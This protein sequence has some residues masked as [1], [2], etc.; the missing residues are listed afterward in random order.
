MWNDWEAAISNPG[1][2]HASIASGNPGVRPKVAAEDDEDATTLAGPEWYPTMDV[3]WAGG[4]VLDGDLLY[5]EKDPNLEYRAAAP[6]CSAAD[7]LIDEFG[8]NPGALAEHQGESTPV[9]LRFA[10]RTT[11][12]GKLARS[13]RWSEK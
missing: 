13:F 2:G 7:H 11:L 10:G 3:Q 9:E 6:Q 4:S 8:G 12:V 1:P 5:Q